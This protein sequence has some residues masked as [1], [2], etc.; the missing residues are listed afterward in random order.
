MT[1][2]PFTPATMSKHHCRMLQVERFFRQ[3]RMLLRHCCRFRPFNKVETSCTCSICFDFVEKDKISFYS[4]A[5][6]RNRQHC[7][8]KN[9]NNVEATFDF[10]ER[11]V[12]LVVFDNVSTLLLVWTGLNWNGM[13]VCVCLCVRVCVCVCSVCASSTNLERGQVAAAAFWELRLALNFSR[14][15]WIIQL[16]PGEN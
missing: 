8:Q 1:K 4:V 9:G 16:I 13:Q 15:W 14:S 2:G 11:I 5:D 6:C 3:S 7:C 10:V 12:R